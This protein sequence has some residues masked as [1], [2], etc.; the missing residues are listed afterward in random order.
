MTVPFGGSWR[1]RLPRGA[2]IAGKM[3]AYMVIVFLQVGIMIVMANLLFNLPVGDSPLALVLLTAL[4]AL[5]VTAIGMFI[6]ALTRSE[7]Q[8]NAWAMVL[9]FVLG[10]AGGCLHGIPVPFVFRTDGFLGTL[11]RLTPQGNAMDAYLSVLAQG[12]GVVEILPQLGIL[13]AMSVG[14]YLI[15][16]WRFR[17]E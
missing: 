13:L 16:V 2:I 7:Q 4:L 8:A 3:L 11:S 15:A 5:V 10:A 1:H 12:A 14:L 9:A 17:F 6:V